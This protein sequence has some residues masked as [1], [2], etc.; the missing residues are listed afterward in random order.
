MYI[1]KN[2]VANWLKQVGSLKR[3]QRI[4]KIDQPESQTPQKKSI[5]EPPV[6]G[7]PQRFF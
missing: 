6:S 7:L 2:G 1:P 3:H 4:S 5:E